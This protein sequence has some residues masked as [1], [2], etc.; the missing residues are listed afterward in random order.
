[1]IAKIQYSLDISPIIGD[2]DRIIGYII[3]RSL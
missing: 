1:M 3:N 2:N